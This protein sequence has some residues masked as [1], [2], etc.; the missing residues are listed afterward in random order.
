VQWPWTLLIGGLAVLGW[1]V[2]LAMI[3]YWRM[4]SATM[5]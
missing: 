5:S 4:T 1:A 2:E 3:D